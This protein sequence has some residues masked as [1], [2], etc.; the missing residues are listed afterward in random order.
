M[1]IATTW[2]T[3]PHTADAVNQAYHQLE[4]ALDASPTLLIAYASV[5][6]E[7]QKV[8]DTLNSL[9]PDVPVHGG[10]SCLGVMTADGFHAIDGTGF[11]LL[12]IHDPEGN[13]GVG[14]AE[15]KDNARAAGAAAIRQAIENAGRFGEPPALV[16]LG[17]V[18][19]YEEELL[20][21]IQDVIGSGVPIAGGSTADNTVE[22]YWQQY[23]N[24]KV[25]TSA[26]VVTAM[27]PSVKTHLAFHSG[28]ST[29]DH[30]GKVTKAEGRF[31]QEINGRS[32]AHVYN[33]WIGGALD[34]FIP[35]GGNV[36]GSTTLYPLARLV[37]TIGNEP[38]YR[39]SHPNSITPDGALSLFTNIE[40]GDEIILMAGTKASLISRAGR[41][42]QAALDH[43]RVS[44]DQI[45]G[46]LVIYCAGCMLTVQDQ[47]D[48]VAKELK[49][50]LHPAPFIGTFTFGEQG[51]FVGGENHHGNLMISVVVFEK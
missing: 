10:T 24:G 23:A 7:G 36:L 33:E 46:A 15:I 19:G 11:G 5:T 25:Y 30:V 16:W 17:G 34:A 39:L 51:C 4:K 41:V 12:G 6:H 18:P 8:V 49:K 44:A 9:A 40:E 1:K 47:M 20:L 26:V 42:A 2:S 3:T 37:G 32:A 50:A 31:L 48:E 43:G 35:N 22:G 27:Y 45:S 21:G 29:T 38:Y 13:Y 28:Y 14:A